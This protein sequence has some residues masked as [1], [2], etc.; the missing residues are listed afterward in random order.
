M[1]TKKSAQ[2]NDLEAP[3]LNCTKVRS[4]VDKE[5]IILLDP[6]GNS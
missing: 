5:H 4:T 2:N 6:T 1:T 3:Y